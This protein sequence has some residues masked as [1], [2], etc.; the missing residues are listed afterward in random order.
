[1]FLVAPTSLQIREVALPKTMRSGSLADRV[2]IG[3]S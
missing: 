3:S 1:M 2:H